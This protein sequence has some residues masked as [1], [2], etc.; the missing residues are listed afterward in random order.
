MN[1][2]AKRFSANQIYKE[3]SYGEKLP[4]FFRILRLYNLANFLCN[5]LNK[6]IIKIQQSHHSCFWRYISYASRVMRGKH[7]QR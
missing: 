4:A 5:L 1:N 2:Y 3:R 7:D 6:D